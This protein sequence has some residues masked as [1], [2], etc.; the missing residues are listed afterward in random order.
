MKIVA[1]RT[2]LACLELTL[3]FYFGNLK[4][5]KNMGVPTGAELENRDVN[6]INDHL[7]VSFPI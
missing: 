3:L 1:P 5:E 4:H 2:Q 6:E 7:K